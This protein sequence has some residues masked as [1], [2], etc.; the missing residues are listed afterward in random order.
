MKETHKCSVVFFFVQIK[1][2]NETPEPVISV[3]FV[4]CMHELQVFSSQ[5]SETLK[6][7]IAGP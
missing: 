3:Q 5:K 2:M 7:K 1:D 6:H 4:F